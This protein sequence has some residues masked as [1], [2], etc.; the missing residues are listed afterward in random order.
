VRSSP[1]QRCRRRHRGRF[2]SRAASSS[3]MLRWR[4]PGEALGPAA[5]PA[6]APC[7]RTQRRAVAVAD[8]CL[9]EAAGMLGRVRSFAARLAVMSEQAE[10]VSTAT[11][12]WPGGA[13]LWLNAGRTRSGCPL[14]STSVTPGGSSSVTLVMRPLVVAQRS[15][16]AAGCVAA[17]LRQRATQEWWLLHGVG[18]PR[19]K[20]GLLVCPSG[21]QP[22]ANPWLVLMLGFQPK[23]ESDLLRMVA[24][25]P[26]SS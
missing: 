18:E 14:P 3:A 1:R 21:E 10:A 17:P 26:S 22:I 16:L 24:R 20:P 25:K 6:A 11:G 8:R 4:H 12:A 19:S 15:G 23:A 7:T 13:T 9:A 2:G 5:P